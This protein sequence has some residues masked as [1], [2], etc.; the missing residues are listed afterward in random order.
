MT[1]ETQKT[2]KELIT[3]KSNG[4]IINFTESFHKL[5]FESPEVKAA[6]LD[7]NHNVTGIALL[8]KR[9]SDRINN[10]LGDNQGITISQ[11]EIKPDQGM[12]KQGQYRVEMTLEFTQSNYAGVCY[13][14]FT[15]HKDEIKFQTNQNNTGPIEDVK[16]DFARKSVGTVDI[17]ELGNNR[18]SVKLDE[19][20]IT[21]G[22]YACLNQVTRKLMT[23]EFLQR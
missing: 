20:K 10:A 23:P 14:T 17:T 2:Q 15:L 8:I 4:A 1:D 19:E 11:I 12:T 7:M 16:E 5:R 6:A 18:L 22:V 21:D 9:H 13:G 3:E